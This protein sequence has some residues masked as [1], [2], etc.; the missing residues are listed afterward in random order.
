MSQ[1]QYQ[2]PRKTASSAR[3]TAHHIYSESGD[4]N[5]SVRAKASASS[6]KAAKKHGKLSQLL[7]KIPYAA[8]IALCVILLCASLVAGNAR[9]LSAATSKAMDAWEVSEYIDGRVGEARNLLT[10][11][12]R[13]G[14][15][16]ELA[17]ALEDAINAL[18]DANARDV[19]AVISGNQALE[20]AASNVSAALLA[21]NL[22]ASDEK[23]LSSTM[24]DFREQG[25][26]LRQQARAYNAEA[27]D[28]LTLYNKLPAKFLLPRPAVA[29][30]E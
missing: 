5:A 6:K 23:A 25:N 30:I 12:E 24:D 20:T 29:N 13:N 4:V 21:G 8:G 19:S 26:F 15:S 22:S 27:A 3:N 18:D 14:V 16:Q 10:L 11:C 17:A 28:A 1:G 7:E 9:A 2:P